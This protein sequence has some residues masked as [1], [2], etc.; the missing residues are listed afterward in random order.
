MAA[1]DATIGRAQG[2]KGSEL[3]RSSLRAGA[4]AFAFQQ[5]STIGLNEAKTA[6]VDS[7]GLTA[8]RYATYAAVGCASSASGGGNCGG[9]AAAAFV[10]HYS[11]VNHDSLLIASFV[12]GV[13]S[14]LTGGKFGDE[15]VIGAFSY[16][17]GEAHVVALRIKGV[18]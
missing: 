14:E 2:V 4:T 11:S 7:L 10:S 18:L 5:A 1:V 8:A 13:A 9:G 17:F 6:Y 3:V 12:G 15:M 16:A